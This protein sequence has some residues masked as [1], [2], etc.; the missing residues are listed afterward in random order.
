MGI[1]PG[2]MFARWEV[3]DFTRGLVRGQTNALGPWEPWRV[4]AELLSVCLTGI[5]ERT[6]PFPLYSGASLQ[7][8]P[9]LEGQP[10]PW[11]K[12]GLSWSEVMSWI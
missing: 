8:P 3:M 6:A 2:Q 7:K 4:L 11:K 10:L 1:L 5:T 9:P 12:T